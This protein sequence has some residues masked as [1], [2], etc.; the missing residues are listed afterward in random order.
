VAAAPWLVV[1]FR[2][3]P[4]VGRFKVQ[5]GGD[6]GQVES[7][8]QQLTD[9]AEPVEVG[10]AVP[11]GSPLGALGVDEPVTLVGAQVLRT[12]TDQLGGNRDAVDTTARVVLRE[13]R[14]AVLQNL[15]QSPLALSLAQML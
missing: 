10:R 7:G 8:R 14:Q 12:G 9:A 15:A 2:A 6:T 5:D 13:G 4:V 11:A 1:E 3:Q